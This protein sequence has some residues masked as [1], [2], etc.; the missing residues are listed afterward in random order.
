MLVQR[1]RLK[2]ILNVVIQI[3]VVKEKFFRRSGLQMQSF[4]PWDAWYTQ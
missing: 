2:S 3:C 1:E 4:K